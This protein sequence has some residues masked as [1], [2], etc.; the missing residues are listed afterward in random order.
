MTLLAADDFAGGP[1]P[2]SSVAPKPAPS[3]PG[4]LS[5][6]DFAGP[7]PQVQANSTRMNRGLG[8]LK[9][10]G[11]EVAALADM[12]LSTPG[13]LI[14]TGAELEATAMGAA[15]GQKPKEAYAEGAR[16]GEKVAEPFMNPLQKL[17]GMF[18][19]EDAYDSAKTTEGMKK[20]TDLTQ[21]AGQWVE[22]KSGGKVPAESVGM[23]VDTLMSGAAGMGAHTAD[24]AKA[25]LE[26]KLK[27]SFEGDS[28][29]GGEKPPEPVAPTPQAASAQSINEMLNIKSANEQEKYQTKRRAD[30]R[31]A[32]KEDKDYADYLNFHATEMAT[33]RDL[34]AK[35]R[36]AREAEAA[37]PPGVSDLIGQI[38][39]KIAATEGLAE[40][41]LSDVKREHG[42][43]GKVD[44]ELLIKMGAAATGAAVYSA[45]P[46]EEKDKMF[47]LGAVLVGMT[48]EGR[49]VASALGPMLEKYGNTTR[50]LDRLGQNKTEFSRSEIEQTLKQQD[51]PAAE[52]EIFG[53]FLKAN[54]GAKIPAKDLVDHFKLATGD[55][56]L[57]PK[58]T[59]KYAD[60]GVENIR[61]NVSK[62]SGYSDDFIPAKDVATTTL[63]RLPEHMEMSA[64]N[65]FDDPRL[66][67]WTRSF[68]EDGVR[69]VVEVQSDL[70]QHT[71][72]LT[73]EKKLELKIAAGT[74]RDQVESLQGK[75]NAALAL[76]DPDA[77]AE[78]LRKIV[79]EA[80]LGRPGEN[81]WRGLIENRLGQLQMRQR[82]IN[83]AL[84]QGKIGESLSPALKSWPRRLIQE[85]LANASRKGESRVRFASADTVA[86]VEG[87]PQEIAGMLGPDYKAFDKVPGKFKDP[88]HQSIYNRYAGDIT[89]YLKS[90]GGK[91][92]T[93]AS[94]HTWIE[95]STTRGPAKMFGKADPKLLGILAGAAGGAFFDQD[96]PF[97][98]AFL[99]ALG[100]GAAIRYGS[101]APTATFRATQAA[102]RPGT[103]WERLTVGVKELTPGPI[104]RAMAADTRLRGNKEMDAAEIY[105]GREELKR[106]HV[107]TK[108]EEQLPSRTDR[109]AAV[110][111]IERGNPQGLSPK[112]LATVGIIQKYF[113]EAGASGL[114]A[115]VIDEII[116]RYV[117][118]VFGKAALPLLEKLNQQ[119]S[120]GSMSTRFGEHRKGPPTIAEINDFMAKEGKPLITADPLEIIEIYGAST[121]SAIAHKSVFDSWK[122]R[123]SPEGAPLAGSPGKVPPNYVVIRP[124]VAV[125]PDLAPSARFIFEST[126]PVAMIRAVEA[127]N[128]VAK[129]L[130]VSASFFHAKSLVDAMAAGGRVT[131][132]SANYL[133]AK[134]TPATLVGGAAAG[135]AYGTVTDNDP[136]TY[137]QIG[138]GLTLMGPGL[139]LVGQAALPKVFGEN[140]F[141][142]AL[143]HEDPA[144][145]KM[146]DLAI[147][148]GAKFTLP[149]GKLAAPEL[150]T[151]L[152]GGLRWLSN[153]ADKII[154]RVPVGKGVTAVNSWFNKF[155]WERLHTGGKLEL[156]ADKYAELQKNNVR[157][158]E[159]GKAP[160]RT[161]AEL[162]EIA[163]SYSNDIVGGLNW[164]RIAEGV[165]S[166]WGRDLAMNTLNPGG[167]R[168]MRLAMFA[169]DWDFSTTRAV[170]KAAGKGSGFKGTFSPTELADLH[171]QYIL[172]AGLFYVTMLDGLNMAFT[173]HHVWDNK[174]P[175]RLEYPDGRTQQFSAHTMKPVHMLTKPLPTLLN[176]MGQIPREL[177]NQAFHTEYLAP[178][179]S[180]TG[181]VLAGPGM[182]EN[183]ALH[184]L[185][186]ISPISGQQIV[187]GGAG[188]GVA[189]ALGMPIYGK[190]HAEIER[191]K[192][193][194]RLR[195]ELSG[196]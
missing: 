158:Y 2:S 134:A 122:L 121:A 104:S 3:T 191:A 35:E 33:Y 59:E 80:K 126:S 188:S 86:K 102:L 154:P 84:A 97:V 196:E 193:L 169:P 43:A 34:W 41:N 94:G 52:K 132:A 162:A 155:L 22:A 142:A 8:M 183:R 90:L 15:A 173:G 168:V 149:R 140:R 24:V 63:Y 6:D 9:Q 150:D 137:A 72:E 81:D 74:V 70:A 109:E 166:R 77:K 58:E 176:S 46:K 145:A 112:Q 186:A 1:V 153:E 87:W 49:G 60:Y 85:E 152:H 159:A 187:E 51:I 164:R 11:G 55:F 151:S 76:R 29:T 139:R 21:R 45:L 50:V 89:R 135:A 88:A 25:K 19:Q 37:K 75:E 93:D 53:D 64:A 62:T 123:K 44:P 110:H 192:E 92:V 20:I 130:S 172:R 170:I 4:L 182:K 117:T 30:V 57:T 131:K 143:R 96:S 171:R 108:I 67:G 32:F 40:R 167:Q 185:K 39:S 113:S 105:V 144:L 190:S 12:I 179:E 65:H 61:G 116:P 136:I 178:R 180:K 106:N 147:V 118:H 38:D 14:K 148:G 56:K 175:T 119:R 27:G 163:A 177:A 10:A 146:I 165:K 16:I 71:K 156:F 42:Q 100:T 13:M 195:K 99:G 133:R 7:S 31:A 120:S 82:E 194:K 66:F 141:V 157:A 28:V 68:K 184:A 79:I 26:G 101:G 17:L 36:E 181:Q 128:T 98:G 23:L 138:A 48:T 78:A 111:A 107:I 103:S 95:V 115:G 124:G 73:H 160:L 69:H 129:R 91:E 47:G 189:S 127:A 161:E 125:H 114:S 83:V 174:D 5:A 18:H 54:P